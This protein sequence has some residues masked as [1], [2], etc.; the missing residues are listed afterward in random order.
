MMPPISILVDE[1]RQGEN[2]RRKPIAAWCCRKLAIGVMKAALDVLDIQ[3]LLWPVGLSFGRGSC[4][5]KNELL[6]ASGGAANDAAPR[7]PR[8]KELRPRQSSANLF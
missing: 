6:R 7:P 8:Q 3:K 5:E 2:R 1:T 4:S